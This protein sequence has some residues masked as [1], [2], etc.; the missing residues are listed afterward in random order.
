MHVT[1]V[2]ASSRSLWSAGKPGLLQSMGWQRVCHNWVTEQKQQAYVHTHVYYY[3][4]IYPS[5][6][7]D[8][9]KFI[10]MSPTP[11]QYHFILVFFSCISIFTLSHSKK[12]DLT[13]HYSLIY[14][15]NLYRQKADSELLYCTSVWHTGTNQS[16]VFIMVT[17]LFNFTV[18]S[19]NTVF[20]C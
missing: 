17:F 10:M 12:F 13:I 7:M 3:F 4:C 1:W 18:F 14:L 20:Q 5:V 2:W 11:F 9:A 8:K 15:V 6:P 19:L 16:T